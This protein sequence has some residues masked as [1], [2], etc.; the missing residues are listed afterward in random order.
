M[1]GYL[2]RRGAR[3]WVQIAVPIDLRGAFG[4]TPGRMPL[5]CDDHR[6]ASRYAR[7][8]AGIAESWCMELKKERFTGLAKLAAEQGQLPN[9]RE[10]PYE[11]PVK[12]I[13][14][15]TRQVAELDDLRKRRA[16]GSDREMIAHL[17]HRNSVLESILANLDDKANAI[18]REY[19]DFFAKAGSEH[20]RLYDRMND[21]GGDSPRSVISTACRLRLGSTSLFRNASGSSRVIYRTAKQ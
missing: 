20:G 21:S 4:S 11:Q 10:R 3:F 17:K 18:A 1:A 15:I 8:L 19:A 6:E 2:R 16:V 9:V 7:R 5:P 13:R 14:E 12:E